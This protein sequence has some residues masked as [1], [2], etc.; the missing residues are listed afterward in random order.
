M[1]DRIIITDDEER[2]ARIK[3]CSKQSSNTLFIFIYHNK[4]IGY[5]VV[6]NTDVVSNIYYNIT[7]RPGRLY[8]MVCKD[9]ALVRVNRGMI[10]EEYLQEYDKQA[11]DFVNNNKIN[12]GQSTRPYS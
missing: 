9:G 4:Q 11:I 12:I 5:N 1:A 7:F 10:K 6:Q 3:E 2:K 8:Y